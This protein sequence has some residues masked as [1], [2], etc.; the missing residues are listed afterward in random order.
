MPFRTLLGKLCIL[1]DY[2]KQPVHRNE[3]E[4]LQ[5]LEVAIFCWKLIHNCRNSKRKI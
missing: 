3:E 5:N 2:Y 4:M 1:V